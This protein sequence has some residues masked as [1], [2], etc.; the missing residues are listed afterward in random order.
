MLQIL[1]LIT[2]VG[3][4]LI[5][6]ATKISTPVTTV[7]IPKII[8]EEPIPVELVAVEEL[9]ETVETLPVKRGRKPKI[10]ATKKPS[11]KIKKSTATKPTR[12]RKKKS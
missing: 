12:G 2:V 3:G 7:E 1:L 6:Y 11:S 8:V 5:W 4:A 10:T 9:H